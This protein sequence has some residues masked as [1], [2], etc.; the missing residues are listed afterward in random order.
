M[1][2]EKRY[3]NKDLFESFETAEFKLYLQIN[4]YLLGFALGIVAIS[5][6]ETLVEQK[7]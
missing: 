3:K 4:P 5:F 7:I 6:C 2:I 1:R